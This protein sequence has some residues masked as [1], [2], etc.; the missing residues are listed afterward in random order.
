MTEPED[1]IA[2]LRARFLARATD[3]LAMLRNADDETAQYIAHR[4][5]GSA[6]T[7]GFT[8]I[9]QAAILLDEALDRSVEA[10]EIKRLRAALVSALAKAIQTS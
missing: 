9:S 3:D 2:A 4:L 10:A 8:S 1:R 6:G 7:F 5:A